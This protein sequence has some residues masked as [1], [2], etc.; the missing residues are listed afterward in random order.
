M[1]SPQVLPTH[2]FNAKK[3]ETPEL[4]YKGSSQIRGYS[5]S[6]FTGTAIKLKSNHS[7]TKQSFVMNRKSDAARQ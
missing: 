7:P 6:P 1:T 4:S 3:K 2:K 5:K